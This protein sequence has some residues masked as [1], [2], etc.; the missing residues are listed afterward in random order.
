[1]S[2]QNHVRTLQKALWKI[3]RKLLEKQFENIVFNGKHR[4][5]IPQNRVSDPPSWGWL[6]SGLTLATLGRSLPDCRLSLLALGGHFEGPLPQYNWVHFKR[7]F[8]E[9]VSSLSPKL[10]E[11]R[12]TPKVENERFVC[13]KRL[14]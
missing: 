11:K 10:K 12:K 2:P 7:I 1:M 5:R 13:T 8:D 9:I 14:F 4:S 3:E 6:T